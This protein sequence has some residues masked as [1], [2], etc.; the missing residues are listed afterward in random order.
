MTVETDCRE[1]IVAWAL[2]G[3]AN[4]SRFVY[5]EGPARMSMVAACPDHGIITCDCSAFVTY[6]FSWAGAVDPNGLGYPGLG[7]TGTLLS[8]DQHIALF[9]TLGTVEKSNLLPGDLIVYGPGTG[10]HVAM[11]VGLK[12][13]AN[14]ET[15]SMGGPG[16]P[17]FVQVANGNPSPGSVETYLRPSFALRPGARVTGPPG[18]TPTPVAPQ[19]APTPV[20]APPIPTPVQPVPNP[21]RA[22]TGAGPQTPVFRVLRQ[23][24]V[25]PKVRIVQK[26]LNVRVTGVYLKSTRL[27]VGQ[28]QQ[29]KGLPETGVVDWPTWKAMQ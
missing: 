4:K 1:A 24:S 18:W 26:R 27:A 14:P 25:G 7:Y 19:P 5:T 21:V 17:S 16:D 15:V 23:W 12:D 3:V 10:E 28:F 8:H 13:P 9:K 29:L 11:I 22:P 2:W 20:P 6:C